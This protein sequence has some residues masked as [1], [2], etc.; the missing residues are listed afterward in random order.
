MAVRISMLLILILGAGCQGTRP[1]C[2][3]ATWLPFHSIDYTRNDADLRPGHGATLSFDVGRFMGEMP[4]ALEIGI[5]ELDDDDGSEATAYAL[6]VR[7]WPCMDREL[8]D[9]VETYLGVGASYLFIDR[10]AAHDVIGLGPEV[11]ATLACAFGQRDRNRL[12]LGVQAKLGGWFGYDGDNA[13][14]GYT[15]AAGMFL[16]YGDP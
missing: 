13:V 12:R 11:S 3:S 16:C 10:D 4:V 8:G 5:S 7:L 1:S 9:H 2:A 14:L 6:G 15:A